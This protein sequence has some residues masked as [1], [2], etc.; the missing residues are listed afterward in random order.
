MRYQMKE[1]LFSFGDDF[2]ILDD[3]GNQAYYVDGRAFSIGDKLSLLDP[4]GNE[5]AF[6]RQKLLAIGPTYEIHRAGQLAAIVKKHLFTFFHQRF[7]VDV[8]G[9][10]DLE[11]RG[12]FLQMEYTFTRHGAPVALVSKRW[13]RL[14]DTYGIDI[15]PDQDDILIL[16]CAVVIDLVAHPDRKG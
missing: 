16:A 13:F 14:A 10:D 5:V 3:A 8:P 15:L 6:I 9:P 11:A 2:A 4:A 1:R 12:D 7:S